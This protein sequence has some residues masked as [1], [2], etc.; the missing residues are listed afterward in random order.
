MLGCTSCHT[1]QRIFTS[2]HDADEFMQIFKRMGTYSPGSTPTHPQPLLPG[3]RGE[4]A[5]IARKQMQPTADWLAKR[6][7]ERGRRRANT[8]LKTLPRPKGRATH[9]IITEYDLPR[10]EA[11]PHDV[12]VDKDG[13]VWYS[14]FAAQFAGYL[15]PEDR[16]GAPTS[17]FRCSSPS[18]PRATS[19]SRSI[20]AEGR[21]ARADVPGRHRPHRPRDQRSHDVP[22]PEGMAVELDAGLDG[23]AATFQRRRQ[24]LDQQPGIPRHVP[25]G[26]RDPASSRTS[27]RRRDR[28]ASRFRLTACRPTSRT[29]STSSNSAAPASVCATP[30]PA[31]R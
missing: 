3:P 31:R 21:L 2:T 6:Q 17:R 18:S 8:P 16:Q 22:V 13:I 15:D 12:I 29:T 30:R 19:K 20:R 26:Y 4:R 11:Q 28:T 10:K 14:D 23:V 7:S 1:F 25:A 27:A 9:V 24:G 5:P